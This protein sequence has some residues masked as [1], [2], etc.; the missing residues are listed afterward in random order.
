MKKLYLI[1]ISIIL[2][3]LLSSC[4]V[5]KFE[6][7]DKIK[8]PENKLPPLLGKWVVEK[9][10][11]GTY[12]DG[13]EETPEFN[14]EALFHESAAVMGEDYI[15]NPVY[16]LKNVNLSDYLLYKYKMSPEDLGL[17]E[18]EVQI[19][20]V[21]SNNQFFN[22]FIKYKNDEVVSFI[23]DKFYFFKRSVEQVSLEEIQRYINVEKNIMR[24]S[25]M[26]E[27]DTL[28]S[29]ILL[30]IKS[31]YYDEE[32][33]EDNW[34]YKT[35]WIR[36]NNRDTASIYELKDGLLLPRKKGFWLVD[37]NR[38]MKNNSIRDKI[39]AIQIGKFKEEIEE[40]S[41]SLFR[42]ATVADST[43]I[44]EPSILKNILYIGNDYIST[45]TI[46]VSNNRKT[47]QV[48][49]IDYLKDERSIKISD[50]IGEEGLNIFTE[51]AQ[52]IIKANSNI[53]LNEESFG[54]SRRN[55]YWI[56]KGRINYISGKEELYKDYNIKAIPPKELVN[57]DDLVIPWNIIKSKVP[58]AI[59]AFT[60]PNEDV[61]LIVTRNHILIY[62]IYDHD[63]SQKEIG[64]IK[65]N[66]SDS[67]VMAEWAV[68][69]YTMIW[70]EE[71]IKN[72]AEN[73]YP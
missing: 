70:E 23:Q 54:L 51:G 53:E 56:M 19:I 63:I 47:I 32:S 35:L 31:Y 36:T 6:T 39:N 67:I 24:I 34:N 26:E 46:D 61:I 42:M 13:I 69:R 71:I 48:S 41:L 28:R 18:G 12:S 68:G 57:Y 60:S 49:P 3:S 5:S 2:V 62:G 4:S 52:G 30:G 16:K 45:E 15:L 10:T 25:G 37:V 21:F 20:T 14:K 7:K 22:E 65:L 8:A 1:I 11:D 38:E 9:V 40:E 66:N 29:G 73:I 50:V 64:K 72:G 55:G 44:V 58:E 59:D 43:N 17:E 27:V 33:Q